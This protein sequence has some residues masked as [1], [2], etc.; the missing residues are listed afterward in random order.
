MAKIGWNVADAIGSLGSSGKNN[1]KNL[2]AIWISVRF[3]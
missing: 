2:A 1:K 3:L